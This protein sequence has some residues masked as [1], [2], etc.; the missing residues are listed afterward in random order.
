[1]RADCFEI[2]ALLRYFQS[3]FQTDPTECSLSETRGICQKASVNSRSKT[4]TL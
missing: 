1:M 2:S 3:L 4:S